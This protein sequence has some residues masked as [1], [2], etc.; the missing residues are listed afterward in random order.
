MQNPFPNR[1]VVIRRVI[2]VAAAL[3]LVKVAAIQ[4]FDPSYV[5]KADARTFDK[6]TLYPSRGLIYDRHG[7]LLVYNNPIY[8]ITAVVHNMDPQ[9]DTARYCDLLGVT[10]EEF[11]SAMDKDWSSPRFSKSIPFTFVRHI[12]PDRFAS[13]QES[14][15]EFPG[16]YYVL[17]NVRGYRYPSAAHT[18]GYISEVDPATVEQNENTY[19]LGDYIG[20]T[21]IERTYENLLRGQKGIA[22]LLRDNLGREVGNVQE[23]KL[24]SFAVSGADIQL[25]LDIELQRYGEEL[26]RNKKGSIVCIEPATG[27]VLAMIS[28]PDYNPAAL[29]IHQDRSAAFNALLQ[30]TLK[31]FFDRSVM[32]AYAPGSIIKPVFA[33]IAMQENVLDPNRTIYCDGAY[34][35]RHFSYGCHEHVTPYN[36]SIALQHSCNAYFFQTYRDILEKEGF[37]RPDRGLRKVNTYLDAFGL[38][39]TLGIDLPHEKNGNV[40]TVE[41][42]DRLYQ[43]DVWRSTY[44]MSLGIGQGELQL[45]TLQMANLA[46]I[47]ANRGYYVT[48][49]LLKGFVNMHGTLPERFR[50]RHYVP[51][52]RQYFDPVVEGMARAVTAGTAVSAFHPEIAI[53]GK[54]G[55]SQN[56]HGKDHSVFFAF[57]PRDNPQIAIAVYVENAGW[58]GTYA[59]PMASLMIEKYMTGEIAPSRKWREKRLTEAN[60]LSN[61]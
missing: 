25:T 57:A 52:D 4:L 29:T 5:H 24:D 21:G 41:Y 47:L 40:P 34:H 55:T 61:P 2:I 48:P 37:N 58:G 11:I 1:S 43:K 50:E 14:L 33:L 45:T 7:N 17:K 46:A 51:I 44:I 28:A 22:Y 19:A 12:A 15:H 9:M 42:Y 39:Q 54:T 38:G 23:G 10:R 20:T 6:Q 18:L 27:E 16:F 60:L 30:D 8:D 49:H 3:L 13:F 59:A 31:P 26:L 56:P 35:Y 36:V 53:C 32:A